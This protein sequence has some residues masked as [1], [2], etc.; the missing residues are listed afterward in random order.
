MNA[1][2]EDRLHPATSRKIG[3][4]T[5]SRLLL[6][7]LALLLLFFTCGGCDRQKT[8]VDL[9]L[10][11]TAPDFM[12]K[13]LADQVVVLSSLRGKPVILRFFETNCRFCKADTPQFKDFYR[14][15]R[16][17]GLQIYYIGSFYENKDSLQTFIGELQLDFPVIMD[18]QAR[19]A[20]LYN[21]KAYPQTIFIDP[22]QRL[23]G[24]LL[25]GVGLAELEEIMGKYL[26][27]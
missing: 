1:I 5:E 24:A 25:G 3:N 16:D 23:A 10:G 4:R 9:Q 20:D 12:A 11:D 2:K 6:Q 19:L 21:I 7:T 27:Q 17:R 13:D 22:D 26:H 18:E 8:P 15:Y 14:R